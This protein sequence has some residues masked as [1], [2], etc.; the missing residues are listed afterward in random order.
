MS[1]DI[2]ILE[3]TKTKLSMHN[4]ININEHNIIINFN[5]KDIKKMIFIFNSLENG[6][7][8]KKQNGCYIF[9][10]KH[11]GKKEIFKDNYLTRFVEENCNFKKTT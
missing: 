6:W 9:K 7:I 4:D 11:E 5:N 3:N 10:K 1:V 2:D 8:I